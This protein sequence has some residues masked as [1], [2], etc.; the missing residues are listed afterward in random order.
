M[1]AYAV[2]TVAYVV[3]QLREVLS[4]GECNLEPFGQDAEQNLYGIV[5]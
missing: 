5:E 4:P 1:L 2:N 3:E